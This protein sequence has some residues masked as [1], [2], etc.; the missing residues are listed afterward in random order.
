MPRHPSRDHSP[1]PGIARENS[2][3]YV[4]LLDQYI[5]LL[6]RESAVSAGLEDCHA[7]ELRSGTPCGARGVGL[8]SLVGAARL[9]HGKGLWVLRRLGS[10]R[11]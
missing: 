4:L 8:L 5:T 10:S 7:Q 6:N 11:R 3:Q 1:V 9:A 2:T